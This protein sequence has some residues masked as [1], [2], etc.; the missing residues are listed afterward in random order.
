MLDRHPR[1][2]T[3]TEA[4]RA[5]VARAEAISGQLR[6]LQND[7][8][9]LAGLRAGTLRIGVFPTFAASLLPAVIT[10]FR[11]RHPGVA[12]QIR[13]SRDAPIRDLLI[14]GDIDVGLV[15][16]YPWNRED[17][18]GMVAEELMTDPTILLLPAAHPLAAR[19]TIDVSDLAHEA[20]VVRVEHPTQ[21]VLQRCA[22]TH[23]F[24]P[25]I[26]VQANDYPEVQAMIAAGFGVAMCPALA[27]QPL[28]DDLVVRRLS[29]DV[30]ARR[31]STAHAAGRAPS[32]AHTAMVSAMRSAAAT[33]LT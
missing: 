14:S 3:L 24:T 17:D 5:V 23:G 2:V 27:T 11:S 18:S 22:R 6:G 29:S 20:W 4:G 12:L 30:P 9:D 25:D 15:W 33:S 7:L 16:D 8:N 1:G 13:S 10:R 32:P 28:R 19:T 31:I 26:A 21:D